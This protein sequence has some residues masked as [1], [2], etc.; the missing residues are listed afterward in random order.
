MPVT[1]QSACFVYLEKETPM[2]NDPRIVIVGAGYAGLSCAL[3]IAR[4]TRGQAQVTLIDGS[5]SFVERIRLHEQAAGAPARRLP[6]MDMVH[7]TGVELRAGW[8]EQID[9]AQQTVRL[10]QESIGWD[11][12]VLALGSQADVDAVPGARE[13]AYTLD[14]PAMGSLRAV[15]PAIAARGGRVVVAGGGLTGIEAASE[16]AEAF[17]QLKVILV[18]RGELAPGFSTQ[19]RTHMRAALQRLGVELHERVTIRA[20]HPNV[21]L[22]DRGPLDF[23]ACIWAVGFR[24]SPLAHSAGL[25]GNARGQLWV[26]AQLRSIS[27]PR[28]HVAGDLA[29]HRAAAHAV[30]MGCKAAFPTGAHA[31]D[32]IVRAL[33][34]ELEQP[35]SYVAVPFCVSLGRRDAVLELP[36]RT[37]H[38][39]PKL[40]RGRLAARIKELI[41][42]GTLWALALERR[43]AAWALRTPVHARPRLAAQS[44]VAHAVHDLPEQTRD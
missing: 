39:R 27:H 23:A 17:P 36:P 3:R 16:L 11:H 22:T 35:F 26:D 43:R 33:R 28:V 13:L 4:K 8:V 18:A 20:L 21:A 25:A 12:L 34:G 19:A 10:A 41:C 6:L 7:D 9:L 5:T 24:A 29:V 44:A 42:R 15:L 37:A 31:A 40:L 32:N 14:A 2:P 1:F 38:G 30:P